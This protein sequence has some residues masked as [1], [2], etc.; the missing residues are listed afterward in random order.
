VVLD[1]EG[2]GNNI[3]ELEYGVTGFVPGTG[4]TLLNVTKPYT[5]ENLTPGTTYDFYVRKVCGS[6][7]SD[8]SAVATT[9]VFCD[10]PEPTGDSNQTLVQDELLSELV[11]VGVNLKY[12][13]DPEMTQEVPASTVMQTSGTY[14]VTQTIN[15]ESDSYLIV[16]V[17]VIPRIA[18]PIVNP[19]QSFCD[20]GDLGDIQVVSLPGATVIWYETLTSTTPLPLTTALQTGTYYVVQTDNVTVSHR[21]VINVVVNPTPVDLVS[22]AIHLCG[23]YTFG[24][25]VINNLPGTTVKWYTS[26]TSTTPIASN[27][28]V[29][30]GTYYATQAIGNCESQR[31]AYQ[32]SQFGSL[33]TPIADIQIFC[34]S[35][36]VADLEANGV[37]GAQMLWYASSVAVNP[38]AGSTVLASGTYYVAQT[39]N[40]CLSARRAVAVRVI[41]M[42]APQIAPITVCGSGTVSNLHIDA[43]AGV[44]YKW[45]NSPS[46]TTELL[47]TTPLVT[48]TY[49]VS[50]MQSGCESARAAVQVTLGSIPEAPTGVATQTFVEGSTISNLV[51]NQSNVVWYTSFNNSQNGTNPLPQGTVLVNG[52]TYYGVIIGSN[53]CPSL[54]FAVTVDIYLSNNEFVKDE[55]KYYPNPV[56]DILNVNYSDR[57]TQVEIFDLLGKRVKVK[58]TDDKDVEID[59][60]D[61]ASGTYMVQLKTETKSQFIKIIKK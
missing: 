17:N 31:V 47:Q 29:A 32:L 55:L 10:T 13:T 48:G 42:L 8:W 36:T 50:R 12:Y 20:G 49:F 44:T 56:V 58:N 33:N 4:T 3:F 52:T 37:Q 59:L 41:S 15:C 2:Q 28:P 45:Y 9:Y 60:S 38:L 53:G 14:F 18:Q 27:V 23:E 61:L 24:N 21:L 22:Q 39:I 6:V 19:N 40:G 34:G 46:S 11:I 5:L 51:M 25:L 43:P 57:I 35:G 1:W 30:T 54:P 26:L 16:N 7:N